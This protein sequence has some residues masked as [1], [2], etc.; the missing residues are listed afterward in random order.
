MGKYTEDDFCDLYEKK[1]CDNCGKCLE[2]QG[3]DIRA[4]KIEDIAKTVEENK[5][6]EEE[7][8]KELLKAA[9]EEDIEEDSDVD[10][11]KDAYEKLSKES[12]IDF[13]SLD[14]DYEDAFDHIEYLD[15][16]FFEEGNLEELTE[17][18]FPG[19][20]KLKK[21]SE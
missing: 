6:L 21:K 19:V 11:L 1:I 12:G 10:L 9:E 20:R 17:E 4:I 8:K 16:S 3:V 13:T 2:E 15:E 7:Y 14:E 5:F 18:I